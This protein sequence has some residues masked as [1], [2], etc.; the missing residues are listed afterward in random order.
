MFDVSGEGSEWDEATDVGLAPGPPGASQPRASLRPA[1][2]RGEWD[3]AARKA[4]PQAEEAPQAPKGTYLDDSAPQA[5]PDPLAETRRSF[6]DLRSVFLGLGVADKVCAGG[7]LL[8]L[9]SQLLPWQWTKED[10]ELIGLV[11][12]PGAALLAAS[13]VLLV[14]LRAQRASRR[15]LRWL[16]PGQVAAALLLALYSGWFVR[17][18][19]DVRALRVAGKLVSI[20]NSTAEPA[21]YLGLVCAAAALLGS[22]PLLGRR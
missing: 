15:L 20:A 9:A 5:A 6:G 19:T 14:Y 11:A 7:A 1:R 4:P 22:L 13:V 17:A 21:A 10:E 12:A 18:V 3:K 2:L 16:A 8:L